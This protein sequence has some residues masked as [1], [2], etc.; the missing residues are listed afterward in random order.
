VQLQGLTDAAIDGCS[1]SNVAGGGIYVVDAG[2]ARVTGCVVE[3][4]GGGEEPGD[5]I[6]VARRRGDMLAPVTL[7]GNTVR[8]AARMGIVLAGVDA[9]LSGNVAGADNGQ[10]VD[11]RSVYADEASQVTGEGVVS[12][13]RSALRILRASGRWPDGAGRRAP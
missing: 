9:T 6:L 7:T 13:D 11:G 2:R 8:G 4:V 3:R 1:V 10:S 12:F 5:G